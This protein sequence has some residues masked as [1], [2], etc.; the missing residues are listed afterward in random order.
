MDE[1]TYLQQ[2]IRFTS[3]LALVALS[4]V[5]GY[6]LGKEPMELRRKIA[7]VGCGWILILMAAIATGSLLPSLVYNRNFL[8]VIVVS[9]LITALTLIHLSAAWDPVTLTWKHSSFDGLWL[10]LIP[11]TI[12]GHMWFERTLLTVGLLLWV[13]IVLAYMLVLSWLHRLRLKE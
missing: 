11:L 8:I 9:V 4:V 6:F 7:I 10:G 13:C 12:A 5:I 1:T 3:T 2:W